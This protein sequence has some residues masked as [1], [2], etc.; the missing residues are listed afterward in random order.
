MSHQSLYQISSKKSDSATH[1]FLPP[2][3]EQESKIQNFHAI[4][5]LET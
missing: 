2:I 4:Y 1:D 3:L 5:Q